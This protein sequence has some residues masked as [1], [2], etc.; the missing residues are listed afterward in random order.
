MIRAQ[1][2]YS[3]NSRSNNFF[4]QVSPI[5][6]S[7][8]N[9]PKMSKEFY[10]SLKNPFVQD[11][12]KNHFDFGA[13]SIISYQSDPSLDSK[14]SNFKANLQLNISG[15][16]LSAFN[17]LMK[18][19]TLGKKMIWGTPYSQYVRG[20]LSLVYTW[21]FGKNKKQ[22]VAVRGLGG[23]G[24]AYG[25]SSAI[26]FE[27]LF[28]AG[29]SNSL[30]GWS[31]RTVGPGSSPIDTTFSIPNQTGDFR[32]EANVEYR[33][34]LFWLLRGAVF[35]D[36]GNVWNLKSMKKTSLDTGVE[37]NNILSTVAFNTG[38]GLRVDIQFV[39]IRFDLGIKL[40][41]PSTLKWRGPNEWFA[42]DGFAFQFGIGYPF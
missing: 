15:N 32:L 11:S 30:R 35:F 25:N 3:W 10:E 27:R 24:Y 2:G 38:V 8:V 29:G 21:I 13:N 22:A 17:S 6:L 31:A 16:L 14:K 36:A 19:D 41:E 12:Y 4:Y 1:F 39:V 37:P 18:E 26:P 33:F 34:P 40:Y 42:K 9:L 20:E 23:I 28:W 7:I 5:Q